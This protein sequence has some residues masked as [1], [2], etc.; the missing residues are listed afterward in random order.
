MKDLDRAIKACTDAGLI[1]R[2]EGKHPRIVD[3][4]TGKYVT[5][6]NTPRCPYAFKHMLRDVKKYLGHHIRLK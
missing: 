2:P 6:S 1:H 4:A 3:P 5:F